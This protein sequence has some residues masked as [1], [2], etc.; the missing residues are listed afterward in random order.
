[1]ATTNVTVTSTWTKLA[2]TEDDHVFVTAAGPAVLEVATTAADAAPSGIVGH[3]LPVASIGDAISRDLLGPGYVW[4]RI[5]DHRVTS[6]VVV[7][8][9]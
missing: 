6:Q 3:R 5:A 8:S 1:M 2:N 7:V 9:K 4:C